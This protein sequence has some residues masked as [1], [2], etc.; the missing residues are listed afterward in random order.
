MGKMG[1]PR[2]QEPE[3]RGVTP[4]HVGHHFHETVRFK[5]AGLTENP[6]ADLFLGGNRFKVHHGKVAAR[7]ESAV[8]VEYVG[9]A[10]GHAG[11]EVSAGTSKHDHDTAGHILAA[12]VAGA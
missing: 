2:N 7:G 8:F 3:P 10:S 9:N 6:L 5:I 12:M 4:A 1:V 11:G